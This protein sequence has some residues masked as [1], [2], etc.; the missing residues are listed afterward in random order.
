VCGIAKLRYALADAVEMIV[1]TRDKSPDS[2]RV[3]GL[4]VVAAAGWR[5]RPS[6]TADRPQEPCTVGNVRLPNT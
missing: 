6:S 2:P 1:P 4:S 5:K 3:G